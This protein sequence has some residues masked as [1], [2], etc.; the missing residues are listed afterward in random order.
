MQTLRKL[1]NREL[2]IRGDNLKVNVLGTEY[3]IIRGAKESEDSKLRNNRDGYCDFTT[4][5]I[6]I[7]EM[8]PDEDTVEDMEYYE[9]KVIRHELIHAFLYESGLDVCSDW[10]RN[11][12]LIDWI[13]LQSDKIFKVFKE[14]N[15]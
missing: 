13:A 5:K 6:V 7:S 14:L 15:I 8:I 10:A 4:K 12:E 2:G 1:R 9:K 11:E 3:E